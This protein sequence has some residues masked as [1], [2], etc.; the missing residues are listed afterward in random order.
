VLVAEGVVVMGRKPKYNFGIRDVN[1]TLVTLWTRGDLIFI[2]ERYR[3]QRISWIVR[4]EI[5][6]HVSCME[7]ILDS[8][9]GE[10]EREV[11]Q[12]A[13]EEPFPLFQKGKLSRRLHNGTI[14]V[15][16]KRQSYSSPQL[17]FAE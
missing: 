14:G 17:A 8:W 12:D 6:N 4:C 13:G 3:I 5:S 16:K 15:D 11:V 9:E 7:A 10:Q 2:H 1:R